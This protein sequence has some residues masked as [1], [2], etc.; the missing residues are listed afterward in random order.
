MDR[1][2]IEVKAKTKTQDS[3]APTESKV[4]NPKTGRSIL[5]DGPAFRTLIN[6]G[7]IYEQGKLI[8][9]PVTPIEPVAPVPPAP[10]LS[11]KFNELTSDDLVPNVLDV[12]DTY[13]PKYIIHLSDIH[14]PINLHVSRYEEYTATFDNLYAKLAELPL[15]ES[16]IVVTGDLVD[17]KL[18]TENETLIMAQRFLAT[19]AS[20]THTIVIVGNHDFAE[21][22]PD[23]TDSITAICHGLKVGIPTIH[24]LKHTGIYR[25]PNIDLVFN[26]LYDLK[27]IRYSDLVQSQLQRPTIALYHG[28][29]VGAKH[30][31]NTE[32]RVSKS[33]V[34]P[35]LSDFSGYDMVLLGHLHKR[36]FIRPNVAYAGSLIQQKFGEHETEHGFILWNIKEKTGQATDIFN[37]YVR[38]ILAI[39]NGQADLHHLMKFK[40]RNIHLRCDLNESSISD[41]DHVVQS[42]KDKGYNIVSCV[43]KDSTIRTASASASVSAKSPSEV[44][45]DTEISLITSICKPE[46]LTPVTELHK[47]FRCDIPSKSHNRWWPVRM[48]FMNLFIYGK[49][50]KNT[51]NFTDG[52]I[53]ICSPNMTGKSSIISIL[54]FGLFGEVSSGSSRKSNIMHKSAKHGYVIVEFMC[55]GELYGIRKDI[56]IMTRANRKQ[57]DSAVYK[58]QFTKHS[59]SGTID[60]NGT[61]ETKTISEI[62]KYVG[63]IDQFT[64]NNIISTKLSDKAIIT[65]TPAELAR[66]FNEICGLSH[67]EQYQTACK[68]ELKEI[69]KQLERARTLHN[70]SNEELQ[71][72]SNVDPSPITS[73]VERDEAELTLLRYKRDHLRDTLSRFTQTSLPSISREEIT[74]AIGEMETELH[75]HKASDFDLTLGRVIEAQRKSIMDRLSGSTDTSIDILAARATEAT[76]LYQAHSAPLKSESVLLQT[77]GGLQQQYQ[78]VLDNLKVT[79]RQLTRYQHILENPDVII[80]DNIYETINDLKVQI[81]AL[82]IRCQGYSDLSGLEQQVDQLKKAIGDDTDIGELQH[83]IKINRGPLKETKHSEA[84]LTRMLKPL[85]PV[86]PK[87]PVPQQEL[88]QGMPTDPIKSK[89]YVKPGDDWNGQEVVLKTDHIEYS[90]HEYM[91]Y[92]LNHNNEVTQTEELNR[93]A[94][95]SNNSINAQLRWLKKQQLDRLQNYL[96]LQPILEALRQK[97]TLD[98]ELVELQIL[99]DLA[100]SRELKQLVV[101]AEQTADQLATNIKQT[102][103]D[104]QWYTLKKSMDTAVELHNKALETQKLREELSSLDQKLSVFHLA[105][106]LAK[107]RNYLEQYEACDIKKQLREVD[108]QITVFEKKITHNRQILADIQAK[109]QRAILLATSIKEHHETIVKL[110]GQQAIYMEYAKVIHNNGIPSMLL[111]MRLES[112]A[113]AVNSIF[114]KYTKYRFGFDKETSASASASKITLFIENMADGTNLDAARLSGFE[115]VLLNIAIGHALID[116]DRSTRS[117]IFVIDESLDC[118]DQ[119]RFEKVLPIIFDLLRTHFR[120][121]LVISHRD[122]PHSIIDGKINIKHHNSGHAYS[123]ID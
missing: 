20:F 79:R 95:E 76:R 70:V 39:N 80:P 108:G 49:D 88:V 99:S 41:Y 96:G 85:H 83:H 40:D 37:P 54:L 68:V 62:E 4:I 73:D 1:V 16:L 63:T 47:K 42:I 106:R 78:V 89:I 27:F 56:N 51:I 3:K 117:D 100:K 35:T 114:S 102:E 90:K 21:N 98:A 46:L 22:N 111:K 19:L 93:I 59:G 109:A 12:P 77:L 28:S 101:T 104:L 9:V 115:T 57:A 38:I 55:N 64:G 17:T 69:N 8:P 61:S 13:H 94:S 23:R 67:Y 7:Y 110:E 120:T 5:V 24:V 118:I 72:I 74:M 48:E 107:Y 82:Q 65:K 60:L 75:R 36:Q 71:K 97:V 29:L 52:I 103:E 31:N 58:T 30:D 14:I 6:E 86:S 15:A 105:E 34:Y 26:S 121:T 123:I 43:T 44:D 32:V 33:R 112:F 45:L 84:E 87:L 91:Q 92:V 50:Y 119:E 116:L 11:V 122:I 10:Q 53:D 18:R 81:G 2:R 25:L 113:V 66:H